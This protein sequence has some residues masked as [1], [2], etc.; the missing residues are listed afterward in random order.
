[1]GTK[2]NHDKILQDYDCT[3]LTPI[4][5]LVLMI[6]LKNTEEVWHPNTSSSSEPIKARGTGKRSLLMEPQQIWLNQAEPTVVEPAQIR[7]WHVFMQIN[8]KQGEC[9]DADNC[10]WFKTIYVGKNQR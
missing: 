9:A 7:F 8:W 1:M 2:A 4:Q 3:R 5:V 6:T 10:C